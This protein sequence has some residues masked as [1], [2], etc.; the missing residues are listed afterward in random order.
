MSDQPTTLPA[1]V[2]AGLTA[3][4]N[5]LRNGTP[6]DKD[7]A[8]RAIR[9]ALSE[10]RAEN[11]RLRDEL[12]SFA[13]W[14]DSYPT[15]VWH[16]PDADELKQAH[17]ALKAAGMGGIDALSAMIYRHALENISERARAALA[18]SEATS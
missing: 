8:E 2:Q 17:E 13:T 1:D 14:A 4:L 11:E 9:K 5:D 7:Y 10:A 16:V 15:S 3:A 6:D 12:E 18:S